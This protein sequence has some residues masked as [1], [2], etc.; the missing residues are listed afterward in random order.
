MGRC[1][2][3]SV[4]PYIQNV[5]R[6]ANIRIYFALFR[7]KPGVQA[8]SDRIKSCC[9]CFLFAGVVY[10]YTI[11]RV[12]SLRLVIRKQEPTGTPLMVAAAPR[13]PNDERDTHRQRNPHPSPT[14][15]HLYN[16]L[17]ILRARLSYRGTMRLQRGLDL[18]PGQLS[19]Q[20]EHSPLQATRSV[21]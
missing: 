16:I 18:F 15:V 11:C 6:D 14:C 4:K 2:L 19:R 10:I 3:F 21:A 1:S 13:P 5:E 9:C 12:R 17:C 20:P 8:R 7:N